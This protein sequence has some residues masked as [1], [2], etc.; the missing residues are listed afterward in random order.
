MAGLATATP[1]PRNA[2]QQQ[3]RNRRP[4]HRLQPICRKDPR[5]HHSST[6]ARLAAGNSAQWPRAT[7]GSPQQGYSGYYPAATP[8]SPDGQPLRDADG[9]LIA[10]RIIYSN[11]GNP[12]ETGTLVFDNITGN[13][14]FDDLTIDV[15]NYT[16]SSG[17]ATVVNIGLPTSIEYERF[18]LGD[19]KVISDAQPGGGSPL[20]STEINGRFDLTGSVLIF[21]RD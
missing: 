6:T 19:V 8:Q 18:R 12:N 11:T 4:R 3:R 14:I 5:H 10:N 9:E 7:P 1:I 13:I 2:Q 21:G 16:D 15:E 20:F 17:S